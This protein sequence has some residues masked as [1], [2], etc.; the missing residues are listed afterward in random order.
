[1]CEVSLHSFR[2]CLV[3]SGHFNA[4]L[5]NSFI[6]KTRLFAI[7]LTTKRLNQNGWKN[8][9]PLRFMQGIGKLLLLEQVGI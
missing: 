2:S 8:G 1:M 5:S 6:H 9:A 3:A 4:T 7:R